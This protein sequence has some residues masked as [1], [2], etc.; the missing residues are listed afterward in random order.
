[1]GSVRDIVNTSGTAIDHIA[2]DSYGNI[3]TETNVSNGD[4]FKYAGM[5][6]DAAIGQY[7]DRAR[8]FDPLTG[9]FQQQDPLGMAAGD[10]DLYRYVGNRATNDNDRSGLYYEGPP[11][12]TGQNSEQFQA[13][14]EQQKENQKR[15]EELRD[16][17]QAEEDLLADMEFAQQAGIVRIRGEQFIAQRFA[18]AAVQSQLAAAMK[19]DARLYS[20]IQLIR[21]TQSSVTWRVN[22]AKINNAEANI[23]RLQSYYEGQQ[24]AMGRVSEADAEEAKRQQNKQKQWAAY[25]IWLDINGQMAA[26]YLYQVYLHDTN[27]GPPAVSPP[28]NPDPYPYPPNRMP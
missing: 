25:Q 15:L 5:E 12:G 10:P 16:R 28:Q 21:N 14:L 19:L 3:V 13:L 8:S 27:Q 9:R 7:F 24:E 26:R 6:Y 4:R 18:V 22:G 1:L 20:A 23:A 11:D 17:V 2:Y